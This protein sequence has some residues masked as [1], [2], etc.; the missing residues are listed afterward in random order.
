MSFTVEQLDRRRELVLP[1][2]F[3]D[4]PVSERR[5]DIAEAIRDH[6]VVVIAGETGSGKT[7]QLPKICLEIGP[8]INGLIGHTQPR[9]IAAR[10][11]AERVAEELAR[12]LGSVVGYQVRFTDRTSADALV[13]VMTDGV[14]LAEIAHDRLLSKYD[15]LIIDEAHERSLTID[16]LLGYLR[17]LLPRPP[18]RDHL[19]HDR[20][21]ALRGALCGRPGDGGL[22]SH[23]PRRGPLSAARG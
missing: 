9:R 18:R 16:F 6:Q 5:E 22:G 8:G 17:Q 23:V 14:L 10:S 15:T 19:G 20:S 21:C 13:K 11:V 4:L 12:P 1:L 7:T 3:P 2:A